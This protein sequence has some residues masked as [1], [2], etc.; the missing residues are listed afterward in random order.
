MNTS[1][2]AL[3]I[4]NFPVRQDNFGR[5]C[6]NDLHKSAGGEERHS[7]NRFTRSDNYQSLIDELTPYLAFAPVESIRGGKSPGTYAVKE[8]VYAYAMWISAKFHIAVIRA[9]DALVSAPQ[10][11]LRQ[12]P[13]PKTKKALPGGLSLEQQDCIKA[14][15]KSRVETL[16]KEKQG[17]AAIRCWSSIKTKFGKTY[18]EVDP[19]NFSA[20]ISL[21]SRL[22]LEGELL[23][24]QD[25]PFLTDSNYRLEARKLINSH[26]DKCHDDMRALGVEPPKWPVMDEQTI[27]GLAASALFGTRWVLSFDHESI[28]PQLTLVP[29]DACVMSKERFIS[30]L[31]HEEGYLVIKKRDLLG[32]LEA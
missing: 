21:V 2:M 23:E 26:L 20:V 28:Q 9:Y 30:M 13:E 3:T 15:V 25:D 17:G 10:Y 16:P 31:R 11:G 4:S 27:T 18:K 7:P 6:L 5:F 1:T 19:E 29:N 24:K 12:L 14:L 8:L 22:P 32:K